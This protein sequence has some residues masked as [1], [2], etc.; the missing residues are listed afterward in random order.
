MD[1]FGSVVSLLGAALI[2]VLTYF[3]ARRLG[4]TDIQKAVR[5][6]TDALISRLKDRVLL[7]EEENKTLHNQVVGLQ[8]EASKMRS[9][10]DDLEKAL[11][12]VAI[13]SRRARRAT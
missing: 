5:V 10:I 11:A 2:L 1:W 4:L 7:L 8:A 3:G 13:T 9:R 6:E 12:D